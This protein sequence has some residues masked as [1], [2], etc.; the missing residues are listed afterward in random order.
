[1]V[2]VGFITLF[3]FAL[4]GFGPRFLEKILP[5]STL[6]WIEDNDGFGG[7]LSM[8]GTVDMADG[9]GT[10]GDPKDP[11]SH[12]RDTGD[13]WQGSARIA[14]LPG[15]QPVFVADVL[16]GR[17]AEARNVA[18]Q[19]VGVLQPV[20]DCR[21]TPPQA[22]SFVAHIG[23][24]GNP[25]YTMA[26]S[27]YGDAEL[28]KAVR[29]FAKIYR[30][31]G[32]KQV[33]GLSDLSFTDF[34]VIVTETQR[35]VYL[36]LESPHDMRLW[37]ILLAP[38]ARIE[39]VVLIGGRQAGVANLDPAVPVEVMRNAELQAC[40]VPDAQYP[41]NPGHMLFQSLEAGIMSQDEAD[42][43]LGR[44]ATRVAAYERWFH[45]SFGVSASDTLAGNW[46]GGT[47]AVAGPVPTDPAARAVWHPVKDGPALITTDAYVEYPALKAEG[48]D[49]ASR[50][51]AIATAFAWGDLKNI[52]QGVEF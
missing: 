1:M 8:S 46:K 31:S 26:L 34:D 15:N 47:V 39:R 51:V 18:P 49:F 38:G 44:I 50:V 21:F 3:M 6:V 33:H 48:A 5:E 40:G 11:Y 52:K 30:K 25:P 41:L 9:G 19:T 10:K 32:R 2:I 29:Q 12:L 16:D 42:E 36:V 43:S 22:G 20:T 7:L 17:R 28:A 13:G 45:E 35:P 4:V 14:A 24:L 23:A 27:T 37:N